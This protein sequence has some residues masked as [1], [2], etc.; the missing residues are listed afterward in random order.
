MEQLASLQPRKDVSIH[1]RVKRVTIRAAACRC[2]G[3]V[4]IHTRVKR[5]TPPARFRAYS[6][7]GFNPHPREAGD[8]RLEIQPPAGLVSIHTRVKRVT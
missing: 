3:P 1:T 5:V 2:F 8:I 4:S 7:R 6:R